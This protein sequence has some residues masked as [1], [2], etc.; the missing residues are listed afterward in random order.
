MN[1]CILMAE[2]VEAPQLRYTADNQT[3][4]AEF[5][6][7][8][9]GLRE[10]DAVGQMKVIGWGNL[11][12]EI[13]ERYKVGERVL[14]EGRL[15][16]NTLERPEGFKEKRAE[17]TVQRVT[18]INELQS[19]SMADPTPMPAGTFVGGNSAPASTP[20][21]AAAPAAPAAPAAAAAEY[22]DIPF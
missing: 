11:A 12:Q 22:D 10:G 21:A 13:Q 1:N 3:P 7:K 19:A 8:F 18:L 15:G 20:S 9:P 16:M 6:V 2:I 4:I 17:I 14:L 5:V